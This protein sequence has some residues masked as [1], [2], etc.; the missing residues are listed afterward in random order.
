MTRSGSSRYVLSCSFIA[1]LVAGC[2]TPAIGETGAPASHTPLYSRG[3]IL[4]GNMTAAGYDTPEPDITGVRALVLAFQPDMDQYVY[5]FVRALPN[6]SYEYVFSESWEAKLARP[7]P[8]FEGLGLE[9]VGNMQEDLLWKVQEGT[10]KK[11]WAHG[12]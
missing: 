1:L 6:G 3:D 9:K 8:V 4:S 2:L 12:T 11:S 7:R 5:T 10:G